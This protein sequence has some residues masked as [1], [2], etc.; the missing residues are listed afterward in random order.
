MKNVRRSLLCAGMFVAMPLS[1]L[2]VAGCSKTDNTPPPAYS[3]PSRDLT[4]A[5][6]NGGPGGRG[7]GGGG[8][9]TANASGKEIYQAKCGCHGPDGSG[10]KAPALTGVS[11][12]EDSKLTANIHDGKGKMPAFGSQLSDDQIKKVVAHIKTFKAGG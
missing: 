1:M 12:E 5:N 2:L 7:P 3:P 9:I 4:G 8:P 6:G 11:G 10:K